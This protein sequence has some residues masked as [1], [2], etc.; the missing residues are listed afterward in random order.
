MSPEKEAATG[1]VLLTPPVKR[2]GWSVEEGADAWA[3]IERRPWE[4]WSA[5]VG[6]EDHRFVIQQIVLHTDAGSAHQGYEIT[7]RAMSEEG[8][9][10]H[11]KTVEGDLNR[12][13]DEAFERLEGA[14]WTR[15]REA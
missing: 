8:T 6:G 9:S 11:V 1:G 12:A 3:Y 7:Y 2:G 13:R 14:T 10:S 15:E 5:S 4:V